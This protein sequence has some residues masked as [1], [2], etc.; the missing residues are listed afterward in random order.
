MDR[1][2]SALRDLAGR[3]L[4]ASQTGTGPHVEATVLV[5]ERLRISL[6]KFAGS[7]GFESLLRRA[8]V[9]ASADVPA[10]RSVKIG[11]GGRLEGFGQFAADQGAGAAEVEAAVAVTAHLLEL[12]ITFIGEPLTLRLVGEAWPD[13]LVDEAH[14]R[15]EANS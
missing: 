14:S 13:A 5:S 4:A 6:T 9:L 15:V 3:L 7:A 8:L 11:A 2:S 12:M 1:P 10:L